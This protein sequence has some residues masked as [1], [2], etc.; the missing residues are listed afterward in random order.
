MA[1]K[2]LDS[3][4][5]IDGTE[6]NK[7]IVDNLFSKAKLC[8]QECD[9]STAIKYLNTI[10]AEHPNS[11]GIEKVEIELEKAEELKNQAMDTIQATLDKENNLIYAIIICWKAYGLITGIISFPVA[12]LFIF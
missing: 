4:N 11:S 12:L 7:D 6:K 2:N 10:I 3:S 1:N 5:D 9:Y 8:N